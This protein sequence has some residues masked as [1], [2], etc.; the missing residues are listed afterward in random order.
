MRSSHIAWLAAATHVV[1]A[2]GMLFLLRRGLPGFAEEE[3]LAYIASHRAAWL[4]GWL[5]WQLAAI[6]LMGF[7]VVL[8]GRL[9]GPLAITA[10]APAA[11]GLALDIA[12]EARYMGVLPELRGEAFAALDR[13]LEVL[14][15]YGANGLYTVALALLV[16]AGWRVLPKPAIALA[17]PVA[18]SGFALALASLWHDARLE[19]ITSAILFP[20]FTLFIVVIALWLRKEESS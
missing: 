16:I 3:R 8:A 7:Y 17:G 2:A 19:T 4:G 14:I 6:S 5:M 20:L 15:G 11:A 18:A 13:E 10:L 1:A 12:C 9:R